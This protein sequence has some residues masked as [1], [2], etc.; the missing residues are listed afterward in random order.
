MS[1]TRTK[2]T[3]RPVEE[4]PDVG[5]EE[6]IEEPVRAPKHIDVSTFFERKGKAITPPEEHQHDWLWTPTHGRNAG[7]RGGFA[8][9]GYTP[10]RQRKAATGKVGTRPTPVIRFLSNPE[11]LPWSE[12]GEDED[13]EKARRSPDSILV[14]KATVGEYRQA[15]GKYYTNKTGIPDK[16]VV[17]I[18]IGGPREAVIGNLRVYGYLPA[19]GYDDAINRFLEEHGW[20][21]ENPPTKDDEEAQALIELEKSQRKG[22]DATFRPNLEI[23]RNADF[24]ARQINTGKIQILDEN[25]ARIA[26]Y[27]KPPSKPVE[28]VFTRFLIGNLAAIRSKSG[29]SKAAINVSD[30]HAGGRYKVR[31]GKVPKGYDEEKGRY[32]SSTKR[33]VSENITYTSPNGTTVSLRDRI[34][35][36]NV[37]GVATLYAE[38]RAVNEGRGFG[39]YTFRDEEKALSDFKGLI[40]EKNIEASM[41]ERTEEKTEKG[42]KRSDR[43]NFGKKIRERRREGASEPEEGEE[44]D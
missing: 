26:K 37:D 21:A 9:T 12:V 23:V 35:S 5:E 14:S 6:A 11:K 8:L 16:R 1:T 30:Y 42:A 43:D 32:G 10:K 28:N 2:R 40:R 27:P 24:I 19:E 39:K 4:E 38:M 36:D 44:S 20:S 33:P 13:P 17:D 31:L 25:G 15:F 29:E 41:R 34:W 18:Y 22:K 3:T 7:K